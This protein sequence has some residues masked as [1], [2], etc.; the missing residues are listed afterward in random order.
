MALTV[1]AETSASS[2]SV[3]IVG[4]D[5]E[6]RRRLLECLASENSVKPISEVDAQPGLYHHVAALRPSVIM[7]DVGGKPDT[8][9]LGMVS[10]L[11]AM[12]RIIILADVDDDALAIQALK[13][14]ASGF[15]TRDTATPLLRKAVQ[16]VEA[17][18]IWVGRRVM[19]RLIEELAAMRVY[20]AAELA[21]GDRLTSRERELAIMVAAG[22]SNKEI[23]H[24]LAISIKTVKA[25]LTNIFKK[26]GLSTR[27]Q[28][29]LTMGRLPGSQTKVG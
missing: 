13:A 28:L 22:A 4:P 5:P 14:G 11:S 10:A 3:V 2:G 19:L 17:G 26:L 8:D 1:A 15:C 21:D 6:V 23:A 25:H 24:R 27:L 9:A 29:A 16:L 20:E 18:E 12:A 7:F